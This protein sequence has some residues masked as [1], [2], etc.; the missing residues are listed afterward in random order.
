MTLADR[1]RTHLAEHG[2]NTKAGI[3]ADLGVSY[4]AVQSAMQ[5]LV[6][7]GHCIGTSGERVGRYPAASWFSLERNFDVPVHRFVN[8]GSASND[9]WRVWA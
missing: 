7:Q 4:I 2:S 8:S 5:S 3:A 6:K 1:I 9:I